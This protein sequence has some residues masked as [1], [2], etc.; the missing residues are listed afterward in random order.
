MNPI[1]LRVA[2]IATALVV[3]FWTQKLIARKCGGMTCIGDAAHQFTA[4]LHLYFSE[5]EKSANRALIIS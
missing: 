4:N 5:N 3:W 2:I 1:V